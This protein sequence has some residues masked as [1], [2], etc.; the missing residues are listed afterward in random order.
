MKQH[1]IIVDREIPPRFPYHLSPMKSWNRIQ[2]AGKWRAQ[3][4]W[5]NTNDPYR[6]FFQ[7]RLPPYWHMWSTLLAER[8]QKPWEDERLVHLQPSPM[9]G[10]WSE[11]NLHED[12]FHVHLQG[13]RWW[14]CFFWWR[15]KVMESWP[16]ETAAV[17]L[18]PFFLDMS[19]QTSKQICQLGLLS[20]ERWKYYIGHYIYILYWI[21]Y[22]YIWII[23][24]CRI[25]FLVSEF[26]DSQMFLDC[27]A[28]VS[29]R[30]EV[31][32]VWLD[33]QNPLLEPPVSN[34]LLL[35]RKNVHVANTC[36]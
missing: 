9:K 16:L 4:W 26:G 14:A 30:L 6:N 34:Q 15:W 12:M 1:E 18:F 11:P 35:F 22:I 31:L 20:A 5:V 3:I 21:M 27:I 29:W 7:W 28:H 8:L 17:T 33:A 23:Y 13:C 25:P 2:L 19:C 10:T 24:I 32:I 36:I